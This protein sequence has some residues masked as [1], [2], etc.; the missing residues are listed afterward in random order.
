MF[1]FVEWD[2][3][4]LTDNAPD[5]R[6]SIAANSPVRQRIGLGSALGSAPGVGAGDR[7]RIGHL[8]AVYGVSLRP[9]PD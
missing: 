2:G 5:V 8:Q 1:G 7:K 6:F 4:S 9:R 3:R